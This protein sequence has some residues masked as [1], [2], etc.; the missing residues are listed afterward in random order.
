MKVPGLDESFPLSLLALCV[1]S[2]RLPGHTTRDINLEADA[3][4]C[5]Q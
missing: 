4:L 2:G 3:G 1:A 5:V